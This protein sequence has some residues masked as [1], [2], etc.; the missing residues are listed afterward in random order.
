M[1]AHSHG[2]DDHSHGHHDHV[3]GGPHVHG[4]TS[5]LWLAFILNISFTLVEFIGG[6]WTNSMAILADAV[7]DLGDSIAI[8][9][10]LLL[11]RLASR[12]RDAVYS[13]GYR[14]L[15]PLSALITST[16]L[17]GGSVYM[18]LESVPRILEPEPVRSLEMIGFAI[19][20][21][22]VN[23]WAAFRLRKTHG[24]LNQRAVM[25]HLLED[26]LGWAAVLVGAV[27]IHT[28]QWSFLDGWLSLGIAL[29]IA[30]QA[31]KNLYRLGRIFLQG[32]PYNIDVQR[33]EQHIRTIHS[34]RKIHDLHVWTL[35]GVQHILTVH[36]VVDQ[37]THSPDSLMQLKQD[38]RAYLQEEGITHAT[39][40]LEYPDEPCA[41]ED[42]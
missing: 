29:F 31:L 30:F 28:L 10:A 23:G 8:G 42:C 7:H 5:N 4:V 25:L 18:I 17:L 32:I 16:I 37:A 13:Y 9:S 20:G 19:L 39:I 11:E 26:I 3:P 12:K 22:T 27:L 40:E 21:V 41:L 24:N 33:I 34:V 2:H 36:I 6:Y 14:R 35:D 1:A 38:V 15:S